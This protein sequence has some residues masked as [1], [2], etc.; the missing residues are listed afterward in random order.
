ML[1][2]QPH[3]RRGA[4]LPLIAV[5]LPV[6]MVFVGFAVDLAYMQ[7]TRLEMR[8][9]TD[10][11]ARAAATNL[12]YTDSI[13]QARAEAKRVASLNTVAGKPLELA[14]GDIE[15]GR[16]EK[17][18]AGKWVFTLG[19]T[20]NNSVRVASRRTAS[21]P[22]GSVPMF[23]GSFIGRTDFEPTA[24]ATASF[25]NVDICLVLD[26]SS[27]MKLGVDS[28]AAGMSI[29]DSRFCEV[30]NDDS[31]WMAL[32]AA[33]RVFVSE[34][35][36][37]DA[38][39]Q[40]ALASYN[41]SVAS[42]TWCGANPNA[43]SLD[44]PLESNLSLI[45]TAISQLSGNLW[46]G[47]TDIESGMRVAL[48]ELTTAS[49]LRQNSEKV[50]IVF[51]DGHENEGSC[52]AAANDIAAANI[53]IHTVTLGDYANQTKMQEVAAIGGGKHLHADDATALSAAF[54]EL[55]AQVSQLTE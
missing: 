1:R 41:S 37:T 32:D 40:V 29:S 13:S 23:F 17:N 46:N 6:L 18:D 55:A 2:T 4:M 48:N 8:A 27:S 34:L 15:F 50:V 49:T 10:S 54:R 45:E 33:V 22:G 11:A 19:G 47:N 5:M 51:T 43:A 31:R 21:S 30:P 16:S 24:T 53:R 38:V 25:E 36:Q 9:A 7:N 42:G 44:S 12:S 14:N 28:D 3:N 39:E 35:K 26:R 52:T 20:P